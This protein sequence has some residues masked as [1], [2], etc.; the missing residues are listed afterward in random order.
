MG[1]FCSNEDCIVWHVMCSETD[2]MYPDS[3]HFTCYSVNLV[4]YWHLPLVNGSYYLLTF[5]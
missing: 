4:V 3:S 1:V 2:I 5:A